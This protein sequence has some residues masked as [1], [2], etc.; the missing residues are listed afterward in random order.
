M[1]E[2]QFQVVFDCS[3]DNCGYEAIESEHDDYESAK[4]RVEQIQ[5]L[6]KSV[7][8][9]CPHCG[10]ARQYWGGLMS[11]TKAYVL[12]VEAANLT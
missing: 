5:N 7:W 6:D 8:A 11:E 3:T 12:D 4:K 9:K 2:K 10:K 1:A